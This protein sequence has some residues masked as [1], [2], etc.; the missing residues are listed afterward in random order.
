LFDSEEWGKR[1]LGY[2]PAPGGVPNPSLRIQL[3]FNDRLTWG[4][5]ISPDGTKIA[6][7]MHDAAAQCHSIYKAYQ[8]DADPRDKWLGNGFEYRPGEDLTKSRLRFIVSGSLDSI[9]QSQRERLADDPEHASYVAGS[10]WPDGMVRVVGREYNGL[11]ETACFQRGEMSC[12]SCHRMHQLRGDQRS[13]KDWANDQL[14]VGMKSNQACTQCHD[15]FTDDDAVE[16]HTHHLADSSGSSCYNCHMPYTT[17]GLLKAVRSHQIESP[18]VK[19][20][21]ETGRPNACNQCH[22]DK[23]LAWTAE[24]LY[25]R[26]RITKPTLTKD[27]QEIAASVLWILSGD[28]GQRALTAW[29]FGWQEA[30]SASSSNWQAP[31]LAQLLEDPYDAV[32]FIAYRSLSRMSGFED[33]HYDFVGPREERAASHKQALNI[34]RKQQIPPDKNHK[35]H[36]LINERGTMMNATLERL[37]KLRDD[38][39]V[40]LLE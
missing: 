14:D 24:H 16:N 4:G 18:N 33:F 35:Q 39:P 22:L 27:E 5:R 36:V 7:T 25:D 32:R 30:R 40:T 3:T 31:L 15:K 8:N 38:R 1:N 21:Q 19:V 20:S 28:A 29:S 10:F 13:R 11:T 9:P 6:F 2:I 37:L 26:Y 23:T 34:W 17:Y 12:L